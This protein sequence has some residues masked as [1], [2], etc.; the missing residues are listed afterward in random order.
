MTATR[1]LKWL[2]AITLA[3]TLA[4]PG[5]YAQGT[6]TAGTII[7][8]TSK[9]DVGGQSKTGAEWAREIAAAKSKEAT[10]LKP[11][12]MTRADKFKVG[13]QAAHELT[14]SKKYDETLAKLA[15]LDA[16]T[17][18]TADEAF[19]L[20]RTRVAVSSLSGDEKQLL[21]SLEMVLNAGKLSTTENIE[22][23]EV[24]T[25]K[26]FNQKDF[27]KTIAW[28]TKYFGYG[29]ND[30]AIRRALVL[31]YYLNNEFDRA[32]EEVSLDIQMA[33]IAGAKPTEEQLRLW[34]SCAQKRDDKVAYAS[35]VQKYAAY[36]P[37]IK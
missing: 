12:E 8:A 30:V 16:M 17:D 35:A 1:N 33:E 37:K 27:A 34:V 14:R 25:R 23:S 18:K 7:G 10:L 29:G 21:T 19:L 6:N 4:A 31:S 9:D 36:Y 15:E 11:A 26:Y 28:A 2:W 20:E 5:A 13:L 3:A 22:F 32:A 24:L